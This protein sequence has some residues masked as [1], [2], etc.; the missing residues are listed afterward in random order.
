MS[1][2]INQTQFT[3]GVLDTDNT[4]TFQCNLGR[5]PIQLAFRCT[6]TDGVFE[7]VYPQVSWNFIN[8]QIVVNG[9]KGL[10]NT[11]QYTF[12]FVVS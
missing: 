2:V 7:V 9:I 10:T 8:N 12:T 1:A 3:A 11:K 6:R 4:L 5:Q